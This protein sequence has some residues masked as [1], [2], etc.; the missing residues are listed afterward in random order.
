MTE[1]KPSF[2]KNFQAHYDKALSFVR[3]R[4]TD[5]QAAEDIVMD[6]FVSCYEKYDSFDPER[7]SFATW[8]YVV[9]KNKL[10]NYYRDNR[11]HEDL[12][13]CEEAVGGFEDEF[14]AAEVLHGFR[15]E[16][17]QVLEVLPETQKKIVE[18]KYFQNKNATEI[19]VLTG[20]EPGNVRVQLSRALK[21]LRTHF[22]AK[23]MGWELYFQGL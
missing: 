15:Q 13:D 16:L 23:Q 7:A 4:V 6:A 12:D 22:E 8:L 17:A 1:G 11:L 3:R 10:K 5:W 21:K 2:E 20:L 19:A 9:L 18:Y 14:L